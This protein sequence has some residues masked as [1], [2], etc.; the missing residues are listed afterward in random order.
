MMT[1]NSEQVV[2]RA[3]DREKSS[4]LCRRFEATHLTFL[5]AG[6]LVGDFSSVV[7]VLPGSMLDGWKHLSVR[8][9]IASPACR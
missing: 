2:N 5:L 7:F 9:M 1:R 3:V 8:S 6:T 4:N